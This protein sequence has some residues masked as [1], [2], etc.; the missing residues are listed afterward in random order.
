LRVIHLPLIRPAL[1]AA[2]ILVFV[3]CMKELPVTLLLRP[4]NFETLATHIY[5]EAVRPGTVA[6]SSPTALMRCSTRN[7]SRF[8]TNP[9]GRNTGTS[10]AMAGRCR[11][12][13][14]STSSRR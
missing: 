8:A 14:P 7:S 12:R 3:D 11:R 5:G 2:A 10:A 9:H 13:S 1:V 6:L 4:L